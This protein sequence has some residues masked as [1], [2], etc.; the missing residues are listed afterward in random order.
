M[1]RKQVSGRPGLGT[2]MKGNCKSASGFSG[3][4]GNILK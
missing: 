3:G 4:D 2:G 1:D